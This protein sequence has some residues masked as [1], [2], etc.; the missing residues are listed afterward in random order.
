M[1][2]ASTMPAKN[3]TG[4]PCVKKAFS[5]PVSAHLIK[6]NT[7]EKAKAKETTDFQNPS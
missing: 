4:S 2:P 5:K 7:S 6:T 1:K 3:L